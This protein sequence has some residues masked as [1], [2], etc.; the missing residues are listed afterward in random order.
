VKRTELKRKTPL[1]SK[2]KKPKRIVRKCAW[3]NRCKAASV[4]VVVSPEERY[5]RTHGTKKADIL[6]GT[7]VKQRDRICQ[8]CGNP[9]TTGLDGLEWAHIMSRGARYIRWDLLNSTTLCRGC[10]FRFTRQPAAWAVWVE[11]RWPG[12]LSQLAQME[13]AAE[14][15][16]G[17][18]DTAEIIRTYRARV[19]PVA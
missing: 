12:R 11:D 9:G 3:S 6:V 2:A 16:G 19:G 15:A 4:P 1:R 8:S 17:H 13:G 5:C 18:V 14:R 10:H 7:Y